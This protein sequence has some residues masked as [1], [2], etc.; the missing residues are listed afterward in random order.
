MANIYNPKKVVVILGALPVVGFGTDSFIECSNNGDLNTLTMN[1]NGEGTYNNNP[2]LSGTIKMTLMHNSDT[3]I[4]IAAL[5][6]NK[7]LPFPI[8]V[9]DNN[10]LTNK[11]VGLNCMLKKRPDLIRA[12][13][14]GTVEIE[15]HAETL[16][17]I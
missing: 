2:D 15:F 11:A 1:A 6:L 17:I 8:L 9:T 12:K 10:T 5:S 16:T 3:L 4:E 14:V 7:T 13:E